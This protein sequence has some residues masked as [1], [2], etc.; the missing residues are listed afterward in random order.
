[1]SKEL[2]APPQVLT[3]QVNYQ[4]DGGAILRQLTSKGLLPVSAAGLPKDCILLDSADIASKAQLTSI[5]ILDAT[6]KLTCRGTTVTVDALRSGP[7]SEGSI[8]RLQN[9]LSQYVTDVAPG[10][11]ELD[12]PVDQSITEERER[13]KATSSAA[14]LRVLASAP[15]PHPHLPLLAGAF[16][17]D[18]LDSFEDLPAVP[19]GPNTCPDYV[20]YDAATILVTDHQNQSTTLVGA[21]YDHAGI[22]ARLDELEAAINQISADEGAPSGTPAATPEGAATLTA[23]PTTSDEDFAQTVRDLQEHI[24]AGDIFQVVPSR[25]YT[26]ECPDALAAYRVLRAANPSPYMF[27]L[28]TE[29]FQIFGASPESSLLYSVKTGQVA[30][31]P[32]AGTR[33][34]G[35]RADG[36]IDHELDIRLELQ[37]RKDEKELA[38]HLMLVDLARNDVARVSVPGTRQVTNLLRVDRYSR[39]MHLVSEVSGELAPDLDAL[40]AFRASMTMGT[41]TGAP[42]LRAAEL[43]RE[44]EG[45]RRG[46]YGGAV[47]YLRGDG[48]FDTCIVIRSA[49]VKD[50]QALVQAGAGVVGHSNPQSEAA[51]TTHKA[52][53]VLHALAAAQNAKLE[54]AQ[55]PKTALAQEVQA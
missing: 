1:M 53:A 39:V 17:F 8:T 10:H 36:S 52:S 22:K 18:Y 46:S 30:I 11:L 19:E 29:D 23:Y 27:Y 33:P 7:D 20:F 21:S 3:R 6:V 25:G 13:L 26:M 32:I 50:G 34:R 24:K 28:A 47:G 37:L 40:D 38:E 44:V 48:E 31:R 42:K 41:L 49:F 15:V 12:I 35:L 9:E 4:A 45:V 55:N 54:I 14:A 2:P 43:I 5:A 16:A 51:E